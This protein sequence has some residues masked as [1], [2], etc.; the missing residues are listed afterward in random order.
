VAPTRALARIKEAIYTSGERSLAQQLDVER[1]Y[2][3]ELG[4]S[5]DYA[6]GVAAFL[7]KRAA[8]FTGR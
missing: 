2:Q 7:E 3:R 4:H 8:R 6:E 1:D 5:L